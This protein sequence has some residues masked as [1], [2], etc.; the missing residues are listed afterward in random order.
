MTAPADDDRPPDA[1]LAE[2]RTELAR[3]RTDIAITAL[4]C[5]LVK[6]NPALGL[7]TLAVTTV[8][9]ATKHH[10]G[11]QYPLLTTVNILS[12]SMAA[13][14]AALWACL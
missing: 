14:A 3:R 7:P 9:W 6:M 12:I 1:G 5:A 10:A 11:R 13:L 4:G 2:E 8:I